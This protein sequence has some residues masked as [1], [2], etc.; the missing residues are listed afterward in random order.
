M[1]GVTV[2][3]AAGQ[4]APAAQA[5]RPPGS[6]YTGPAFRFTKVADG[7]YHAVGTGALAV[8]CNASIIVTDQEAIVVDTHTTPA[9]AWAL[10]EELRSITDKPVRVVINT[11]W[12]FDHSH[13]NQIYGPDVDIIGTEFTRRMILG[14]YSTK[15]R[16]FDRFIGSIPGQIAQ[17]E[18]RL[19]ASADPAERAKLQRQI[20]VQSNHLEGTKAV[21]ATPPNVTLTD[22]L[23]LYRGG[24]EIRLLFLG[25]GHTGGDVVVFLPRERI[26]ITGDLLVEGT[27]YM[28]DAYV[29][30]WI[31]T[32]DRLRALEFD[33]ILPGHGAV[34]EGTSRIEHWQAYLRDFLG[35]LQA[36]H[37]AGVPPEAAARRI[38]LTA[39][40]KNYPA[41]SAP[42]VMPDG[43]HRTYELLDGKAQ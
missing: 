14:G 35:Q 21:V 11:H 16:A 39:H 2:M 26:V 42:G 40:A 38:D 4:P 8:F 1:C 19:G 15:G 28:G 24:R 6:N 37:A 22:Q 9:G 27:S 33:R 29:S 7:V 32:L 43:V 3:V 25:R 30:D 13:G 41:I 36:L 5:N 10:R 18:K 23:V 20:D 17:T 12:H 34:L 31:Q